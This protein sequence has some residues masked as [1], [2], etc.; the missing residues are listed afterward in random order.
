MH[1]GAIA[2]NLGA[3]IDPDEWPKVRKMFE[4]RSLGS[5]FHGI[6]KNTEQGTSATLVAALD[7]SIKSESISQGL[8]NSDID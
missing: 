1:P 6:T 5:G 3:A 4:E 7:P 2:T 8:T